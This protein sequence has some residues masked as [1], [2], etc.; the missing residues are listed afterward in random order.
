M[1]SSQLAVDASTMDILI[2][3]A[4]DLHGVLLAADIPKAGALMTQVIDALVIHKASIDTGPA[5]FSDETE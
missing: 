2:G 4:R 1:S 5:F 3:D